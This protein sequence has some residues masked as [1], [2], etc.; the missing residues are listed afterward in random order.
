[1]GCKIEDC[2]SELVLARGMCSA[3]YSRWLKRGKP[4]LHHDY[5]TPIQ[6]FDEA[7]ARG[8]VEEKLKQEGY[9]YSDLAAEYNVSITSIQKRIIKYGLQKHLRNRPCSKIDKAKIE[10]RYDNAKMMALAM[11]WTNNNDAPRYHF[12][13]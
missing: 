7:M 1:M 10:I 13:H 9:R 5:R 2:R 8:E 3:H 6:K 11:A 12:H 4:D